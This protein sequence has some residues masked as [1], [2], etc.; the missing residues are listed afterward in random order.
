[1]IM[2]KRIRRLMIPKSL[3]ARRLRALV[4][5]YESL[6]LLKNGV[7]LVSKYIRSGRPWVETDSSKS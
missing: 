3:T 2:I 4:G 7:I 1:M 5:H 6:G